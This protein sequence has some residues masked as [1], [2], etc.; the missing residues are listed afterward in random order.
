MSDKTPGRPLVHVVHC[1]DTEGPLEETIEATFDRLNRRFGLDLEPS[2][3]LLS[4]LQNQEMD[5]GGLEE[6]MARFI[7]PRRLDY[8]SL[9][10]QVEE[11]VAAVSNP[12]FRREHAD[13]SGGPYTLT[14]FI[15]DVV[16]YRDN[17]RR[18]AEGFHVIWDAYQRFLRNRMAGDA[19]GFPL[20]HGRPR[21]PG[22]GI[23]HLLD[24]Q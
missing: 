10:R 23:Q 2:F 13:P 21:R 24:Q 22:P 5:L 8:L 16:G 17:P 7:A 6:E 19:F 4:R 9:W 14:W 3:A 12:R 18:K 1:V 11:S 15:I 20:P